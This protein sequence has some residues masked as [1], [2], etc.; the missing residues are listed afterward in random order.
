MEEHYYRSLKV[1]TFWVLYIFIFQKQGYI[2]CVIYVFFKK[3]YNRKV[4]W[5]LELNYSIKGLL[6]KVFIVFGNFWRQN[7]LKQIEQRTENASMVFF[8]FY[9]FTFHL[10]RIYS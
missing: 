6:L 10:H 8:F 4:L 3:S 9:C 2:H 1:M 7:Y 5:R